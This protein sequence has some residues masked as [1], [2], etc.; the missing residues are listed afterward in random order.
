VLP[1]E[2]D[3]RIRKTV[4]CWIWTG[5]LN[6]GYGRI[7]RRG[8]LLYAHRVVY[9]RLRGAIPT[10]LQLDHL[11]RNTRC[12]NPHHLEPVSIREN[13]RRGIKGVLT[14]HCPKGHSYSES[15]RRGNGWRRCRIC[16]NQQE[17]SRRSLC[18]K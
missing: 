15:D 14:T 16:H 2:N 10:E 7:Y 11:C 18:K 6:R 4:S 8:K 3:P 12:V 13:V 5:A 17:K 9:E 1:I